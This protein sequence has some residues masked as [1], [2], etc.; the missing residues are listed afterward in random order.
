MKNK[1][2]DIRT[3]NFML[4][5]DNHGKVPE[6]INDEQSMSRRMY[7]N[8]KPLVIELQ[9]TTHRITLIGY[10]IPLGTNITNQKYVDLLGID[11]KHN[12]YLIETKIHSSSEKPSD[13]ISNQ[14]NIY[15]HR[16]NKSLPYIIN[17]LNQNELYASAKVNSVRKMLL[18]PKKYFDKYDTDVRKIKSD[19]ILCHFVLSD[20]YKDITSISN[21]EGSIPLCVS[22]TMSSQQIRE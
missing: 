9:G 18:A 7:W 8:K 5:D 17:E 20:Q 15:H 10:E 11:E 6:K 19:V 3:K 12:L 14:I 2:D 4:F 1:S 21:D 13:V 22:N 16:F